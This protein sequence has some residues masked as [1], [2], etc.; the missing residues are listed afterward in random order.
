MI[1]TN[2]VIITS[3]GVLSSHFDS[4]DSFAVCSTLIV[5]ILLDFDTYYEAVGGHS[6]LFLINVFLRAK[7][8]LF[9]KIY[10]LNPAFEAF[11]YFEKNSKVERVDR[12]KGSFLKNL[13]IGEIPRGISKLFQFT[14]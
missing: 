14:K 1:F 5:T 7:K 12:I 2:D 9:Q 6:N 3:N 10:W 13:I 11:C 4:V 8:R